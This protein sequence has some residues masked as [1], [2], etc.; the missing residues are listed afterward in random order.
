VIFLG[1]DDPLSSTKSSIRICLWVGSDR[2]VGV[3][4]QNVVM[5]IIDRSIAIY[6]LVL[7]PHIKVQFG[8]QLPVDSEEHA[9]LI[10]SRSNLRRYLIQVD[11]QFFLGYPRPPALMMERHLHADEMSQ[12][13]RRVRDMLDASLFQSCTVD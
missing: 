9:V 8:R 6:P 5:S 1:K 11:E 7:I 10:D 13:H 2:V 3:E 12:A 4:H